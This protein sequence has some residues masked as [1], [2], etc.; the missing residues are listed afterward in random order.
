MQLSITSGANGT[1]SMSVTEVGVG[2]SGTRLMTDGSE[3]D[4]FYYLYF[5]N[6]SQLV[7][8]LMHRNSSSGLAAADGTTTLPTIAFAGVG[9]LMFSPVLCSLCFGLVLCLLL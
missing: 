9:K 7:Q 8:T 5:Q 4:A 2:S 1:S 3:N 6:R